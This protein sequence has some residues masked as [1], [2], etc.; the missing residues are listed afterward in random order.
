MNE[1]D[2]PSS[3][4]DTAIVGNRISESF[5]KESNLSPSD[6]LFGYSTTELHVIKF[7]G[8]LDSW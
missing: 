4:N 6:Y 7:D 8:I 2:I 5:Y 3:V 1:N